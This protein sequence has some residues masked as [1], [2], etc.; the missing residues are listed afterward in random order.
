MFN[1][2]PKCNIYILQADISRM[3]GRVA[4]EA[5]SLAA[6]FAEPCSAVDA[7]TNNVQE[8]APESAH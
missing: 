8:Y 6:N 2:D 4:R 5:V 3:V 7:T 1:F